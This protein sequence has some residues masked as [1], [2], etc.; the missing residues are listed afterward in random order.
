M[1]KYILQILALAI[2]LTAC[3]NRNNPDVEKQQMAKRAQELATFLTDN[4]QKGDSVFFMHTDL[5]TNECD[6]EGFIVDLCDFRELI[7]DYEPEELEDIKQ[8]TSGVFWGYKLV[9]GL[10][11]KENILYVD[12]THRKVDGRIRTDGFFI[13]NGRW[14]DWD[15]QMTEQDNEIRL[16][17]N[18]TYCVLK[19]NVG[20]VSF[21]NEDDQWELVE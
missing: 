1:K 9:T 10:Q 17:S 3:G 5:A 14:D 2:I 15:C 12:I 4:Y 7:D 19:K 13:L 11:S 16:S 20:I 6:K 18:D 21:C 8:E